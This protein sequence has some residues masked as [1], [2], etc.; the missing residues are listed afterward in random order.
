[1]AGEW[2]RHLGCSGSRLSVTL[3]GWTGAGGAGLW[4]QL[5]FFPAVEFGDLLCL[6]SSASCSDHSVPAQAVLQWSLCTSGE[7]LLYP[8]IH[9]G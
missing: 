2:K 8:G 6:G 5:Q 1:M 3:V 4:Q 7:H 9:L